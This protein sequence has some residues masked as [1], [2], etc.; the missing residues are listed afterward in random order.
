MLKINGFSKLTDVFEPKRFPT[1]ETAKK[2]TIQVGPVRYRQCA[3]IAVG[4]DGIYLKIKT[5]FKNHP[6]IL[7]PWA[8]IKGHQK[9]SLYG[10][11]AIQ[12]NFLDDNLPSLRLYAADVKDQQM[13]VW[14]S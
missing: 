2:T 13:N 11:K 6:T 14:D 7:I 4:Q 10:R 3:F 1:D 5:I 9:S 8:S 12:L